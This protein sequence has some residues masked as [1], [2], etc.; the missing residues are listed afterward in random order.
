MCSNSGSNQFACEECARRKLQSQR[1]L[2]TADMPC[3]SSSSSPSN[4]H[5]DVILSKGTPAHTRAAYLSDSRGCD[6]VTTSSQEGQS[7]GKTHS[8]IQ[9]D[10]CK[11]TRGTLTSQSTKKDCHGCHESHQPS[12]T[13]PKSGHVKA[14]NSDARKRLLIDKPPEVLTIQLKRFENRRC[15]LS[16]STKFVSFPEILELAPFC[17]SKY[18]LLIDKQLE[19]CI[20]KQLLDVCIFA[21]VLSSAITPPRYMFDFLYC[22]V[23]FP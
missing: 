7:H 22:A 3:S 21:A 20:L 14:I 12:E 23:S 6:T 18:M 17:T 2:H 4:N 11:E 1:V 13:A 5:D 10:V 15:R 16:K 19:L 9:P 8:I